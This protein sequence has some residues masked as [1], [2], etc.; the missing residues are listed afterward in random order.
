MGWIV[1]SSTRRPVREEI[2]ERRFVEDRCEE[3]S[4]GAAATALRFANR[5]PKNKRKR[6]GALKRRR[7]DEKTRSR[8]SLPP[9]KPSF[10]MRGALYMRIALAPMQADYNL[11]GR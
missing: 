10:Y 5:S 4:A 2:A 9:P 11:K 8:R 7:R 6:A 3:R 1:V